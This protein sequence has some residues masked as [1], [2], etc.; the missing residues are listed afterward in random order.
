MSSGAQYVTLQ[1]YFS[2]PSLVIYFFPTQPTKLQKYFWHPSLVIYFFP[3]PLIKLQRHFAQTS[4][5]IYFSPT[6]PIKLKLGLQVGERLLIATHLDQSNCLAKST[7][8][9]RLCS[10][11]YQ[12]QHPVVYIQGQNQFAESNWHLL[13]FSSFNF[14]LQGPGGAAL[15]S[16][17]LLAC[18]LGL[19]NPVLYTDAEAAATCTS[20]GVHVCQCVVL[21]MQM[22][23]SRCCISHSVCFF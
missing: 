10:A 11:F 21:Q 22:F 23:L 13:T 15:R 18:F 20:D 2:H 1:K 12:C 19:M 6:P 8:V 14:L 9:V 4:L 5:V 7:A 16:S 3:T 17:C